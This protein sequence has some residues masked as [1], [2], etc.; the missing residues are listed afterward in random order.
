MIVL[1][2]LGIA[3][4]VIALLI[5]IILMLN[6]KLLVSYDKENGLKVLYK[7]LFFTFGKNPN[8]NNPIVK[9]IKRMLELDKIESAEVIKQDVEESGVSEAVK[10]ILTIITLLAGRIVWLLK[11]CTVKKLR[12][13]AVCAD[14]DAADAALDYGLACAAVYPFCATLTS[15]IKT[16]EKAE[17]IAVYCDFD[18]ERK[19]EF[20]LTVSVRIIHLLRALY[21]NAMAKAKTELRRETAEGGK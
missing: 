2:V 5:F 6:F 18:G 15:N 14:S 1:K 10:R 21:Y 9:A 8:P 20:S 16:A 4:G 17:D 12:I 19:L 11:Y 13:F 3:L 7:I